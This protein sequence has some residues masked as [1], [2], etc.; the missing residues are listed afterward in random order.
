[1]GPLCHPSV[2]TRAHGSDGLDDVSSPVASVSSSSD[3]SVTP[4]VTFF[5]NYLHY[6]LNQASSVMFNPVIEV[7]NQDSKSGV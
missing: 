2:A 5:P 4:R 7:Q 3:W 6:K 1:M